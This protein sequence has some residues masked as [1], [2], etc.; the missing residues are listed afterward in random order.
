M[1]AIEET[2]ERVCNR[3]D[4]RC[5]S[6][7]QLADWLDAQDPAVLDKLRRLK[8]GE[9]PKAGWAA[10]LA[11]EPSPAPKGAPGAPRASASGASAAGQG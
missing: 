5:V 4:V 7:R 3:P 11:T 10:Y 6:F 2:I 8:V 9:A 1:R